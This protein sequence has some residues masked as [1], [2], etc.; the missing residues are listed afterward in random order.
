MIIWPIA[1]QYALSV[2]AK[3]V[4]KRI[5]QAYNYSKADMISNSYWS[6]SVQY[7]FLLDETH[8]LIGV[9]LAKHFLCLKSTRVLAAIQN[10]Q[11]MQI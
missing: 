5:I 8:N 1:T 7:F 2:F 6:L 4:Y 10:M 11:S 3:L 9:N